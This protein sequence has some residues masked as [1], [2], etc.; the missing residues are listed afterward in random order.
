MTYN[1][2][3][4]LFIYYCTLFLPLTFLIGSF[5]VNITA[6]IISLFT[7]FWLLKFKE[8]NFFYKN[9]YKFFFLLFILFLVI[10]IIYDYRVSSLENSISYLSNI[11]LFIGL[12]VLILDESKKR[13]KLSKIVFFIVIL[14]CLDSYFQRIFGVNFLGYETQQAG[15]LTS[16]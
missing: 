13:A 2:S 7:L 3:S 8:F 10:S 14:L 6:I 12:S 11:L 4:N 9:Q 1:K 16:F 15:R 5:F